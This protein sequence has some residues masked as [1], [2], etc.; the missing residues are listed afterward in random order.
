MSLRAVASALLYCKKKGEGEI[1][2]ETLAF[3][4]KMPLAI[5]IATVSYDRF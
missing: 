1:E 2:G 5:A 3:T 4:L